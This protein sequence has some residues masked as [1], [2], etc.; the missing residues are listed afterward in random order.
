MTPNE[1][2]MS[3]QTILI[4]LLSLGI[5]FGILIGLCTLVARYVVARPEY[6]TDFLTRE[7]KQMSSPW[8]WFAGSALLSV[9]LYILQRCN[10][11]QGCFY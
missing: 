7:V 1:A 3:Y 6:T 10:W 11:A 8:G 5:V 2:I 4:V 9:L